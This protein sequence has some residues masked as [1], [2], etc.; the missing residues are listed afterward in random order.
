MNKPRVITFFLGLLAT[1]IFVSVLLYV[2]NPFGIYKPDY[3]PPVA[4]NSKRIKEEIVEQLADNGEIN[5]YRGLIL[6]TSSL[7]TVPFH[8]LFHTKGI[9]YFNYTL[10][11]ASPID[12][13]A[14]C[15]HFYSKN[16][17]LTEIMVGVDFFAYDDSK[18]GQE[19]LNSTQYLFLYDNEIE[20]E[21]ILQKISKFYRWHFTYETFR[22]IIGIQI[23]NSSPVMNREIDEY[24]NLL[25]HHVENLIFENNYDFED[26]IRHTH[27]SVNVGISYISYI[28]NLTVLSQLVE[29]C[30]DKKIMVQIVYP[31]LHFDYNETLKK[32]PLYLRFYEDVNRSVS[33]PIIDLRNLPENQV[34]ENFI[35]VRHP[36]SEYYSKLIKRGYLQEPTVVK[37]IIY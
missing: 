36:R 4:M 30:N 17:E 15:K 26:V 28:K 33:G 24:G 16:P 22:K 35:D 25:Y 2:S 12:A 13:F 20:R 31:P 37:T 11:N 14:T 8:D 27:E 3:F 23:R 1:F 7:M 6:G 19:P 18:A 32:H 34:D 5:H 29:W 9:R 10:F 21:T